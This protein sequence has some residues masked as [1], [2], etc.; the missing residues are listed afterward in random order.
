MQIVLLIFRLFPLS[1]CQGAAEEGEGRGENWFDFVLTPCL[2]CLNR[3]LSVHPG[4][5][6]YTACS[7]F[8]GVLF[9]DKKILQAGFR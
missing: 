7:E 3:M 2:T 8:S 6:V 9:E 4:Y 5:I 1:F